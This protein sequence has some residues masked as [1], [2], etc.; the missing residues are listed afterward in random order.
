MLL[1]VSAGLVGK[2][3]EVGVFRFYDNN[4]FT[5]ILF[6]AQWAS[7]QVL[8]LLQKS[9]IRRDK[10]PPRYYDSRALTTQPRMLNTSQTLATNKVENRC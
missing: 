7:T 5:A 6:S 10:Q 1:Y 9:D 8:N 3:N 2:R 4:T